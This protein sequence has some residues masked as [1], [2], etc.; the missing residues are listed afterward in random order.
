[1][2]PGEGLILLGTRHQW[3]TGW[4]K[5]IQ[6]VSA[7]YKYNSAVKCKN[8][9][10]NHHSAKEPTDPPIWLTDGLIEQNSTV[11]TETQILRIFSQ[12]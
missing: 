3:I 4:G 2:S 12:W 6:N 7:D 8:K 9:I 10:L 11:T 5:I 1:M